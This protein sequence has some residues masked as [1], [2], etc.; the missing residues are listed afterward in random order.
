M[1]LIN[2]VVRETKSLC[3][4]CLKTIK[5]SIYEKN[6]AMYMYKVCE[7]HGEFHTLVWEDTKENYLEWIEYGGEARDQNVNS[8]PRPTTHN[9]PHDCGICSDHVQNIST[10]ALMTTNVCDVNCPICFTKDGQQ[11]VY[12]PSNEE[13]LNMAS[14]YQD[15]FSS[16]HPIEL[17]GGEP[18]T[19]DD[20]PELAK[21]LRE[22]GFDH[23]QLN[24]NGIRI[25]KDLDFLKALK[26]SGVTVIYLGFDGFSDKVY[27]K[28]YGRKMLDV[29]LKA[30]ENCKTAEIGVVL[31]PVVMKGVNDSSL[32]EIIEIAKKNMPTVRGVYFQPVSFFGN[33][34]TAPSNDERI[35]IPGVLSC[36]EEQT[37]GEVKKVHFMP[38]GSEHALC[39][40]NALYALNK[41]NTLKA[42]TKYGPRGINEDSAK[43]VSEFNKRSWRYS[44]M[45]TLTIGGM[46]FQDVWNIDVER[47]R[48]CR[49]C[50]ISED[51]RIIPLCTKYVTSTKGEKLYSGIS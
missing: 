32:G 33:Y 6:G 45:K 29:K 10:A 35:T 24:T 39:S 4:D 26:E 23:I 21:G 38:A 2:N 3:P 14:H 40:F 36:L 41:D 42:V 1:S 9:C 17:C 25:S 18:T 30:I 12:K 7:E 34:P 50:I 47:L 46:H 22:M 37:C 8:N 13:L 44:K 51:E 43:K 15:T 11:G 20:L 19:R 16:E 28:K 48:Q 31:V 27:E 5:A 49:L